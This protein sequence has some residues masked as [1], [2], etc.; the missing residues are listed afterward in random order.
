VLNKKERSH[1]CSFF[2]HIRS[3][4]FTLNFNY[5]DFMKSKYISS[6]NYVVAILLGIFFLCGSSAMLVLAQTWTAPGATPPSGNTAAPVNVGTTLQHKQGPL[7]ADQFRTNAY[8]D[9]AG[10]NCL[11]T[12]NILNTSATLQH[13]QGPLRANQFRT[14]E[15]CDAAGNNCYNPTLGSALSEVQSVSWQTLERPA[16]STFG[17]SIRG[18]IHIGSIS[19]RCRELGYRIGVPLR[20]FSESDS[21]AH[22]W[23][24]YSNAQTDIYAATGWVRGACRLDQNVHTALCIR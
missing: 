10:N 5:S 14:N 18:M 6:F 16:E 17:V 8:C 22:R 4:Y 21:V 1:D 12:T 23:C 24:Y 11:T 20:V 13:K 9:A 3:V 19:Q 15:Y 7:R 2:I